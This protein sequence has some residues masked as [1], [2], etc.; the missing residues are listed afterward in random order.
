M[1]VCRDVQIEFNKTA[2]QNAA[3]GHDCA[4]TNG[5]S[6]PLLVRLEVRCRVPEEDPK[7]N[8]AAWASQNSGFS[9][10]FQRI[11]VSVLS[12]VMVRA[13]ARPFRLVLNARQRTKPCR[14]AGSQ[15]VGWDYEG[16]SQV[17]S[18]YLRLS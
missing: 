11:V 17:Q 14:P 9:Q 6:Y 10:G 4:S 12:A 16:V 13:S 1:A 8:Y 18:G 7:K 3:H 15:I 2:Q 5:L